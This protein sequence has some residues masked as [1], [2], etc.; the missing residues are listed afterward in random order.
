MNDSSQ[1]NEAVE[2]LYRDLH[3][4][5][6]SFVRRR[7]AQPDADDVVQDVFLRIQLGLASAGP[8]ERADSWVY[9]IARNTV[10]DWHRRRRIDGSEPDDLAVD[11]DDAEDEATRGGLASCMRPF[12]DRLPEPYREALVLTELDGLTQAEA[13]RRVG[14]SVSGMKT[15][16]QRARQRLRELF[17]A[18]CRFEI[19]R[20]GAVMAYESKRCGPRCS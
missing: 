19:D 13:A 20:R 6:E 1:T 3:G 17:E 10:T 18:C 12:V 9:R 14:L 16:V 11:E 2:A 4:R 7:V 15:R 5:V 8:L